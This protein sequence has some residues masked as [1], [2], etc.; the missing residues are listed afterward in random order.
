M[1]PFDARATATWT[2]GRDF[3]VK[4]TVSHNVAG[5]YVKSKK[6]VTLASV[7]KAIT[8]AWTARGAKVDAG[9]PRKLAALGL[10][11]T[12]RLGYA[13]VD[14]GAW[15]V[16]AESE[17]YTFDH[18][19]AEAVAK[20]VKTECLW[21]ALYGA[22][23]GG[24]AQRWGKQPATTSGYGEVEEL[25]E[26]LPMA[27]EHYKEVAKLEAIPELEG[28][29]VYLGFTNVDPDAYD[30]GPIDD[31]DERPADPPAKSPAIDRKAAKAPFPPI[32]V[33]EGKDLILRDTFLLAFFLK[34]SIAK[35]RK[36]IAVALDRYVAFVPKDMLRWSLL[37]SSSTTVRTFNASTVSRAHT[38][39]AK[40]DAYFWLG[41]DD[42]PETGKPQKDEPH[43]SAYLFYA[44][45]NEDPVSVIELRFAS[46]FVWQVGPDAIVAF[47]AELTKELPLISGY[48]SLHLAR[49]PMI[50]GFSSEQWSAA[51]P[52]AVAHAGLDVSTN[53]SN[54]SE[55]RGKSRGARWL[56]MLGPELAAKTKAALAK[57]GAEV[58]AAGANLVV[59]AGAQPLVDPD[60]TLLGKVARAI[61]PVTLFGEHYL[62]HYFG[63]PKTREIDPV[64]FARWE[65]RFLGGLDGAIAHYAAA[66]DRDG[67]QRLLAIRLA[68]QDYKAA[69]KAFAV[70]E[71][72]GVKDRDLGTPLVALSKLATEQK[73]GKEAIAWYTRWHEANGVNQWTL[74]ELEELHRKCGDPAEAARLATR[75]AK[76]VAK[77]A[78]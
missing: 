68:Q 25:L 37:G 65:F 72:L 4:R 76:L 66:K 14:T 21:Y 12:K 39:L 5:L 16:V 63:H 47:A 7:A 30:E 45:A 36:A 46:D 20:A 54:V 26:E 2:P 29:V 19:I 55:I 23:D 59:R 74:R 73:R 53:D 67:A 31:D 41:S 61:K 78:G 28:E 17:Q 35:T 33:R 42:E 22:T 50:T 69:Q 40:K 27:G 9:D 43:T 32:R 52:L 58:I 48:G 44:V 51:V 64:A 34:G 38:L 62:S 8:R 24:S 3:H 15:I 49:H 18:G 70:V 57:T 1:Y 13:L 75:L 77:Q 56:T 11:K 10:E 6:G 71:K 60:V